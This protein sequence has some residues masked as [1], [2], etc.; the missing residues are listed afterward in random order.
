LR[1]SEKSALFL[2]IT[3]LRRTA[4]EIMGITNPFLAAELNRVVCILM[5]LEKWA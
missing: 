4:A 1:S 3:V 2:Q 5:R